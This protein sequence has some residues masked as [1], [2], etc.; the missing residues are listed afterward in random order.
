VQSSH[1]EGEGTFGAYASG[2]HAM[3]SFCFAR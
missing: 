3:R 2:V 1:G